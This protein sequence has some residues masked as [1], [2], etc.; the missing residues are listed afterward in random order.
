[1]ETQAQ[2]RRHV[3]NNLVEQSKLDAPKRNDRKIMKVQE[4]LMKGDNVPV[5]VFYSSG[6]TPL[7]PR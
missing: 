7:E 2:H 4:T 3:M 6:I 1:M 5:T